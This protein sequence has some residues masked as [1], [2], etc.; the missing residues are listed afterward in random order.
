MRLA[1]RLCEGM[2]TL[3][4]APDGRGRERPV[5]MSE[6]VLQLGVVE[7][8]LLGSWYGGVELAE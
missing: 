8:V 3:G 1:F 2:Q 4:G 6:L 5:G 7:L